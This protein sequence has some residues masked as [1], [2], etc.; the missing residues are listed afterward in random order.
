MSIPF[1]PKILVL[2]TFSKA[3]TEQGRLGGS[4]VERLPSAQVV[5][6]R[7]WDR[8]PHWAPCRELLLPLPVSLM[9]K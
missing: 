4:V 5:I 7:S 8:V 3:I 9:N 6:L 1:D 2:G